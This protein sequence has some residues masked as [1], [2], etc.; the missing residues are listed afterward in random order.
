MSENFFLELLSGSRCIFAS[1]VLEKY[2][3]EA[4][5]IKDFLGEIVD[6]LNEPRPPTRRNA[7]ESVMKSSPR[8]YEANSY[9]LGSFKNPSVRQ[10]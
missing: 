9:E 8:G 1:Q 5:T 2:A 10:N 4:F 6:E 3:L 7:K